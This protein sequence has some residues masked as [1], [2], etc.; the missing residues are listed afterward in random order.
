MRFSILGSGSSGNA[1]FL[2][3]SNARVL[4][5]AGFSFRQLNKRM[6]AIGESIENLDA[7]LISHEHSDH[8]AGLEVLAR[9]VGAPIYMTEMTADAMA[10]GVKPPHVETF[11]AGSRL[12]IGDLEID[13]FTIPH[14]AVDPVGFC[15]RQNGFKVGLVTDLG[16]VTASIKHRI[17]GCDLLMLESNHDLEMLKVGPY[18]WSVKQRVMS[19]VGHLSNQAVGDFLASDFDR[20]T[21][22]VVLAHLSGNNNHPEIARMFAEQALGR[23]GAADTRLLVAAQ[24]QPSEVFEF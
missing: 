4:V 12:S 7:V 19:R 14:D 18:P 21:R 9:K 3:S 13:T 10:W 15:V 17:Q 8:V 23:A 11:A 5:D 22:T 20:S 24:D 2:A 16:Y 6:A 1:A